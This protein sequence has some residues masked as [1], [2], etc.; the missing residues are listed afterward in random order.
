MSEDEEDYLE[1][2][3]ELVRGNLVSIFVETLQGSFLPFGSLVFGL[4]SPKLKLCKLKASLGHLETIDA[5]SP[6]DLSSSMMNGWMLPT[7]FSFCTNEASVVSNC[8]P[9]TAEV[10]IFR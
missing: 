7:A 5:L 4:L 8:W 6:L 1:A 3:N 9:F 10:S 2:F